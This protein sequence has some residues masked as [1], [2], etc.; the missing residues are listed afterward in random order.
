MLDNVTKNPIFYVILADYCNTI[1]VLLVIWLLNQYRIEK[2]IQG[3]TSQSSF[4]LVECQILMF[5][6][7]VKSD[8]ICIVIQ[9]ICE[10]KQ[11]YL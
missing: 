7:S 11:H 1:D 3:S 9:H 6:I 4:F 10:M 8:T 2:V 5:N